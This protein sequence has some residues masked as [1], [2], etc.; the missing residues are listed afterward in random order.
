MPY[1][2][3]PEHVPAADNPAAGFLRRLLSDRPVIITEQELQSLGPRER[4]YFGHI[5]SEA[6]IGSLQRLLDQLVRERDT[7]ERS[8]ARQTIEAAQ[9]AELVQRTLGQ[10]ARPGPTARQLQAAEEMAAVLN[11]RRVRPSFPGATIH[12]NEGDIEP[13]DL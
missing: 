4:E 13:E 2:F 5:S 3:R 9:V 12:S 10:P 7:S 11:R 8:L 6:A 1:I